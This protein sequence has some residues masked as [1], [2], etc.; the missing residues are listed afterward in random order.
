MWSNPTGTQKKTRIK[1]LRWDNS[2]VRAIVPSQN[3]TPLRGLNID[4]RDNVTGQALV[5]C[6]TG[7]IYMCTNFPHYQIWLVQSL[8]WH[9]SWIHIENQCWMHLHMYQFNVATVWHGPA[10]VWLL[11]VLPNWE[12][13]LKPTVWTTVSQPEM[14]TIWIQ[15]II[16]TNIFS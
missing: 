2:P 3:Q 4:F 1:I 5:Y 8:N 12:S 6:G 14:D 11:R 16:G 13:Q 10:L 15:H 9:H 7:Y